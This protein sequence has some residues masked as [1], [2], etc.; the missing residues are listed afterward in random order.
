MIRPNSLPIFMTLAPAAPT[1]GTARVNIDTVPAGCGP[2][3]GAK[4]VDPIAMEGSCFEVD[5]EVP[6]AGFAI[7]Y[8]Y[9]VGEDNQSDVESG[10][11]P[12]LVLLPELT[13]DPAA[14]YAV[15]YYAHGKRAE[16]T[17]VQESK[18]LWGTHFSIGKSGSCAA[19]AT[20]IDQTRDGGGTICWFRAIDTSLEVN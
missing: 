8:T 19:T 10:P 2:E 7:E 3:S 18:G 12:T 5:D 15:I 17:A 13:D 6:S 16:C 4:H 14:A 9:L 20:V 11:Q 1:P